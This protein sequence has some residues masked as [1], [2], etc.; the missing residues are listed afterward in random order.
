MPK[1]TYLKLKIITKYSSVMK[2]YFELMNQSTVIKSLA[3]PNNNLF[4]GI[5]VIHR[6]FEYIL[7]KTNSIENAYFYSQKG[8]YYYLEYLEQINKSEFANAFSHMD[9]IMLVYKKTIFDIYDGENNSNNIGSTMTNL[10]SLN[11]EKIDIPKK[12]L[13]VLLNLIFNFTRTMFFWDNNDFTFQQ[14]IM[15]CYEFLLR[16]LTCVDSL[17]L[18]NSF[19]I[20][21][22]E[23]IE[24][25]YDKYNE[26]LEEIV[27][28]FEKTKKSAL[29][30][31]NMDDF[32]FNKLQ[33]EQQI[34]SEINDTKK[35]VKCLFV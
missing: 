30:N 32:F 20:L 19:I 28:R 21:I 22:Q 9:A 5:N 3:N 24:L 13:H 25:T 2:E 23:K 4:I 17:E 16:F 35:L 6:V 12:D 29:K 1:I 27:I 34:S 7:L 8:C 14:R 10:L 31:Y 18:I 33:I 11:N 15:L 26:V